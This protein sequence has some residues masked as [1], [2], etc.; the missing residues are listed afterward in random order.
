MKKVYIAAAYTNRAVAAQLASLIPAEVPYPWWIIERAPPERLEAQVRSIGPIEELAIRD[1]D[2]LIALLPARVGGYIELGIALGAGVPVAI[3]TWGDPLDAPFFYCD[4]VVQLNQV[5]GPDDVVANAA[6]WYVSTFRQMWH[7]AECVKH[8]VF[9]VR[10]ES[11]LQPNTLHC[12]VCA[13]ESFAVKVRHRWYATESGPGASGD[14]GKVWQN[15]KRKP[16]EA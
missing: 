13:G 10:L 15:M 8:G 14:N 4:G 12:P 9:E 16:R 1:A 6:H 2:L 5:D 7:A 11:D 3:F